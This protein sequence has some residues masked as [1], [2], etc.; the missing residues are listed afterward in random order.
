MAFSTVLGTWPLLARHCTSSLIRL[1]NL[2][3]QDRKENEEDKEGAYEP[4][5]APQ[6]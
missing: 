3:A 1:L 6:V 2:H 4:K 5:V